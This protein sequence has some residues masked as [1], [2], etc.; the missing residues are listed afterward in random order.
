MDTE[1]LPVLEDLIVNRVYQDGGDLCVSASSRGIPEMGL[2]R[3]GDQLE[4]VNYDEFELEAESAE[5]V[6]RV[7]RFRETAKAD[8]DQDGSTVERLELQIKYIRYTE[9]STDIV[10]IPVD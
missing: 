6:E 9:F 5:P 10:N 7:Y 1:D 3:G 4:Q 8:A 2:F